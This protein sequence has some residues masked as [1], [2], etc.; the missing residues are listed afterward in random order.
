MSWFYFLTPTIVHGRK[1]NFGH[2]WRQMKR[3][4][5]SKTGKATPTK[6][7]FYVFHI[8]LYLHEFYELTLI[9]DPHGNLAKFERSKISGKK[10]PCALPTKLG[11]HAH[12]IN[13]YLHE[14]SELIL[15]F[16]PMFQKGNIKEKR[17]KISKNKR[18]HTL[19]TWCTCISHQ[20]L[21]AWHFWA[22]SIFW[23][24]ELWF[25]GL[26]KKCG[27][28]KFKANEKEQNLCNQRGHAH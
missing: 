6:I 18:G 16:D 20:P 22:D 3:N 8:N 27:K 26:K 1:G 25:H 19:Q 2:L 23:S 5:N 21:P 12:L 17:R 9:F 7:G 11:V 24:H 14:F 4:H 10:R 28:N 15:L 13:L